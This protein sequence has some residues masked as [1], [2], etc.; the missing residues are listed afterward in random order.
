M[1]T[2]CRGDIDEKLNSH[3]SNGSIQLLQQIGGQNKLV[4][5]LMCFKYFKSMMNTY[6]KLSSK[7]KKLESL[8]DLNKLSEKL[9]TLSKKMECLEKNLPTTIMNMQNFNSNTYFNS[10]ANCSLSIKSSSTNL[11]VHSDSNPNFSFDIKY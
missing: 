11:A 5:I 8:I 1:L 9:D 2:R 6:Y 7:K 3:Y 4:G 10:N